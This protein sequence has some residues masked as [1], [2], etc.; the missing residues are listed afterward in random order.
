MDLT[1]TVIDEIGFVI[2]RTVVLN[3]RVRARDGK[4]NYYFY[5]AVVELK[6]IENYIV[7]ENIKKIKMK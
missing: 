2:G 7:M 3:Y 5:N 1:A 4:Y 6:R